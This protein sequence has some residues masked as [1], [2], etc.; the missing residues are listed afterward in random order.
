M[1]DEHNIGENEGEDATLIE[2]RRIVKEEVAKAFEA[3]MPTYM[4]GMQASLRKFIS[5]ELGALKAEIGQTVGNLEPPTKKVTYKEFIAC[6][7]SVFKGEVDPL[8]S[9]R[10][11]KSAHFIPIRETYSSERMAEVYIREVVSRHGVPVSIVSDRDTRFTSHFWRKFQ[12]E[13]GTKLLLSTAYHP[14]TDGQSER[15]IQT[16]EDM[17]R[18]C[19]IDFG[20]N[21]DDYLPLAEFSYNN[22][23]HSSLGMPP[24]EML[25]GRKCRTPVCWE[26]VG[27]RELANKEV[28]KA[29]NDKIDQIRVHLKA[30]QDR[31][32]SYADKRR[33]PIEFQVGDYVLLKVSP[34]K[35]V[36]RFR[37][38][39]KLSPRFVGPFK[40]LA[41]V[42]EVAYRLELPDELSGIHNTFHVS[43]L[44]KCLAD[45][46]AYVP[47]EDVEIV[48][49][50]N[51]VEKPVEILDRKV[52]RLRNKSINQ[53]LIKWKNRKGSDVTWE[54]EEE[55]K[56]FY[57]FLFEL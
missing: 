17:L 45:E 20:G 26:E 35:G 32:K 10:L 38:R 40:I 4:D 44:R 52:K 51:Y 18:A 5:D 43:Y 14:Q 19:I 42:G 54:S 28:V 3:A 55:M 56:K 11:T 22:S 9:Q 48:D 33:R 7:P 27:P 41:R 24:Y 23:Y 47:L 29:T 2:T 37:K 46:T 15:T 25:Y 31:Q 53:V 57:P 36:I 6:K 21:W 30:A 1:A 16:L 49:K 39:G 12:E 13:L 50:L 8:L 34:W